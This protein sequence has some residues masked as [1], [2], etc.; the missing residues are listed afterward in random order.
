[1][2]TSRRAAG[3]GLLA[4]GIATP[5]A[6]MSMGS[7]GGESIDRDI[8]KYISSGHQA[9]T[10]ALA[11]LG[12]IAARGLLLFANGM[13]HELRSGGGLL[14]GLAVAATTAAVTGWLLVG[15]M[16]VAFA[17]GGE[18]LASIPHPVIYLLGLMSNVVAVVSSGFFLGAA[19]LVLA[20]RASL[21]RWLHIASYVA[22]LCGLLGASNWLLVLLWLWAIAF[23]VWTIRS[24]ASSTQGAPA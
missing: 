5:V 6:Y 1:M 13:R 14:W 12:G 22:G 19:A 16:A 4:Y 20:A 7:P 21:P 18:S 17:E 9:G 10:I 8:A 11:Y 2:N 23:G 3:F 24:N 15:G